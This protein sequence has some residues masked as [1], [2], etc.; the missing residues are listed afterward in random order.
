MLL[1]C[2]EGFDLYIDSKQERLF[3]RSRFNTSL[4]AFIRPY[5]FTPFRLYTL[6]KY[7]S[8]LR[9]LFYVIIA[10]ILASLDYKYGKLMIVSQSYSTRKLSTTVLGEEMPTTAFILNKHPQSTQSPYCICIVKIQNI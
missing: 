1:D 2:F 7:D 5:D 9:Y 4:L 10:N 8:T 6:Y 3:L